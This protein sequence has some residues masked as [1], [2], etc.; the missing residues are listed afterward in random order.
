M[1]TAGLPYR[2]C[3][4]ASLGCRARAVQRCV[5]L[6]FIAGLP[7]CF[8]SAALAFSL[9]VLVLGL[10]DNKQFKLFASLTGT[11]ALNEVYSVATGCDHGVVLGSV[12]WALRYGSINLVEIM[13]WTII[14]VC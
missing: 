3:A 4:L 8:Y 14:L 5:K 1:L 9:A 6:P 2:L 13:F 11:P 10:S 7:V 12:R